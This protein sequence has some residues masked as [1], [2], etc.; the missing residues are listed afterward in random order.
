M[1]AQV[2]GIDGTPKKQ[3]TLADDVF[4]VAVSDGSIYHAL[5]NELAN[6]RVGTA[7]TKGRSEVHGSNAK[8]WKQKGTG[9]A[10]AGEKRSPVWVGGGTIFGPKPRD[11]SY[12]LPRKVK[13]LAF[14]S[15]LTMKVR[16]ERLRVIEDFTIESGKTKDLVRI[17][18][19]LAPEERTVI[20]LGDNDPMIK[21]AGRN[22]PKVS[23][24]SFDRLR[25]NDLF[26]GS[27]L[28]LLETAAQ[29][30]NA[31][32]GQKKNQEAAS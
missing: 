6:L 8:P 14:R 18:K 2:Y 4:D 24:L 17:L 12:K 28:L 9:R 1:N 11:Y 23:F 5:K 31:F 3:I 16:E 19:V 32:Y 29:K 13:R 21:R 22:L 27:R 10:R 20:I 25:A 7:S 26:Y 15:L 30:L